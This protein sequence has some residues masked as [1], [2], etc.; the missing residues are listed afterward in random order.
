MAQAQISTMYLENLMSTHP[1]LAEPLA[2]LGELYHKKLWHQLTH[3][4]QA[5]VKLPVFRQGDVL[6]QLYERF[7]TDFE[8]KLNLL[9]LA[10]IVV[11]ISTLYQDRA[12]AIK[13]LEQLVAKLT[14][15][16]LPR[17][18]QP[19]LY[20][21]MQIA[22]Q[23]LHSGDVLV[24]KEM[25]EEGK[26]ALDSM[27]EVDP[28][29]HALV[30]LVSSLYYKARQDFAE[31]YKSGMLYLAYT[32]TDSLD[33]SN[34]MAL[35]V[36]LSLAALLG[37]NIY[38]FGELL[39]HPVVKSL[40]GSEYVWVHELLQAF[41]AGD[42][43]RYDALCTTHAAALNAQP[44]LV[45]H[46]RK[47]R[48]KITILCLMEIIFSLPATDRVIPLTVIG[49]KTKLDLDG[50]ESL[51]M[52]SLSVHLIEGVIDQVDGTVR[53]SWVQPRVLGLD[54]IREL[55]GRLDGW[56]DKVHS[57]LL[58]VDSETPELKGML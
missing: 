6:V 46:E 11:E 47:L 52:K 26:S 18:Q 3:K 19:I 25:L 28:S 49:E 40:E 44:A 41:N 34:K 9:T 50:V 7:I 10:Q 55:R 45:Q 20:A 43:D 24:C 42:L 38:N 30:H 39:S 21:R 17:A 29:V 8:L 13:F 4:L 5:V 27:S 58:L 32:S 51:L 48:E 14:E 1:E 56:L 16:K 54:Q 23:K 15:A 57:T 33:E 35:A 37:D 53:I 22:M 31:Y 2:Q 12:V 36:D